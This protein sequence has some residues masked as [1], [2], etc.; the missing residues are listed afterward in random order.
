MVK[1]LLW[2]R[3]AQ[4]QDRHKW[5]KREYIGEQSK[6]IPSEQSYHLGKSSKQTENDFLISQFKGEL[7]LYQDDEF[8]Y[9]LLLWHVY[10]RIINPS[11]P[12]VVKDNSLFRIMIA[13]EFFVLV[14]GGFFFLAFFLWDKALIFTSSANSGRDTP[15]SWD[16]AF[17]P[18]FL[19][20]HNFVW[21][22]HLF[23]SPIQM[24]EVSRGVVRSVGFFYFSLLFLFLFYFFQLQAK[25]WQLS[26]DLYHLQTTQVSVSGDLIIVWAIL[27]SCLISAPSNEVHHVMTGGAQS[28]QLL[29]PFT[30][31]TSELSLLCH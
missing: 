12:L 29:N 10:L 3:K 30:I 28:F 22:S 1:G 21:S 24:C 9:S 4:T 6:S 20:M 19:V 27:A 23:F 2:G 5:V 11:V 25:S 15:Q 26:K 16:W 31:I 18:A 7:A 17:H 8:L 13:D 14:E